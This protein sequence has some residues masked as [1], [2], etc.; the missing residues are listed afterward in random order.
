[1]N[2]NYINKQ[3]KDGNATFNAADKNQEGKET[4]VVLS[5]HIW[6]L[7]ITHD[8]FSDA[9]YQ[10]TG[11]RL[12]DKRGKLWAEITEHRDVE[13]TKNNFYNRLSK[14]KVVVANIT[15]DT[16]KFCMDYPLI[17]IKYFLDHNINVRLLDNGNNINS[18]IRKISPPLYN[19]ILAAKWLEEKES[20][21]QEA[22]LF[23]KENKGDISKQV[24]GLINGL[25]EYIFMA[26]N[27]GVKHIPSPKALYSIKEYLTQQL[28]TLPVSTEVTHGEDKYEKKFKEIWYL[29]NPEHEKNADT[30][31]DMFWITAAMVATEYCAYLFEEGR[32]I[33]NELSETPESIYDHLRGIDLDK[34]ESIKIISKYCAQPKLSP[35]V[36]TDINILYPKKT[37]AEN[38]ETSFTYTFN[39]IV[40]IQRLSHEG[41]LKLYSQNKLNNNE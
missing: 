36:S 8:A 31:K 20:I 10:Q 6:D 14:Y 28:H 24:Q 22:S 26:E 33:N 35:H 34:E 9:I 3:Q 30:G 17:H 21:P 18:I 40:G 5:V 37:E 39:D 4:E 16:D 32:F 38:K 15:T 1:M 13:L 25:N 29:R 12:I 19:K 41:A 11:E 7:N 23:L 2:H 27:I